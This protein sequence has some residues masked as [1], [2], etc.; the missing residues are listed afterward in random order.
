MKMAIVFF[1]SQSKI[2]KHE[3]FFE[4]SKFFSFLSETLIELNFI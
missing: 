3:I 4:N 1:K 2:P